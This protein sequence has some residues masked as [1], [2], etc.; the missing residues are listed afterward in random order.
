MNLITRFIPSI[1]LIIPSSKFH[2]PASERVLHQAREKRPNFFFQIIFY[3]QFILQENL[4]SLDAM[5]PEL[6]GIFS[7][8]FPSETMSSRLNFC[9]F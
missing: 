5:S 8:I 2:R 6:L 4:T 1:H 3:Q 7:R 9:K